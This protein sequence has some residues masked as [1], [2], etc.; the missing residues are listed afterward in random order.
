MAVLEARVSAAPPRVAHFSDRTSAITLGVV[1]AAVGFAGSWIPSYWGDEAASIMSASRSWPSLWSE[2]GTIDAVHGTYYAFLHLWTMLFGTSELATRAPS[3]IAVGFMVA[4]TFVIARRFG[5]Q[6]F[7]LL[8]AV[9]CMVLP[10]ATFLSTEARSYAFAA[11]AAVWLTELCLELVRR[12]APR[13]RWVLYGLAMAAAIY[14]FLYLALLLVV[15]AVYIYLSQRQAIRPWSRGAL[16]AVV[17]ALPIIL[18]ATR[19]KWQIDFLARRNYATVAN[20][21]VKQWFGTPWVAILCWAFIVIVV[22]A[23]L[24]NRRGWK[25]RPAAGFASLAFAWL[26]L[27]TALLLAANAVSPMYNVRYLSFSTPAA[28][29]LI[30]VGVS[31]AARFVA[32]VVGRRTQRR[33]PMTAIAALMVLSIAALCA[34]VYVG[35]RTPFAK[36]GGSD[37]RQVS[38]YFAA[39]GRTGDAVVFDQTTKP[40][41]NPRLALRLYPSGFAGLSDVELLAPFDSASTLW[42]TVAPLPAV[43]HLPERVWAVELGHG[44]SVPPDVAVL[45]QRGYVVESSTVIHRT[46]IYLLE[47]E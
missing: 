16:I 22:V 17:A 34:P 27:P 15:H 7:A 12:Q 44:S 31:V 5:T 33:A 37:L 29:L 10:R 41:R 45:K 42:D 39:Q 32:R 13:S 25:D 30:A 14:L 6:R 35:Q 43:A 8:A 46:H 1:G 38:E 9:V 18:I 47:K 28:A 24:R 2:L 3:A 23:Y 21:L 19:E 26:V 11:A 20:I 40:S 4:G 36:D